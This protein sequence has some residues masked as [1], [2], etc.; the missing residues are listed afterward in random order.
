MM[1]RPC[2]LAVLPLHIQSVGSKFPSNVRH[3]W[4]FDFDCYL[5]GIL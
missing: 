5:R 3:C 1:D 2:G 4:T